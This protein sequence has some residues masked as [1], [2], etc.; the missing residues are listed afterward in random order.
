YRDY[1]GYDLNCSALSG[2]SIVLGSPEREP[3][4]IPFCQC[5]YQAAIHG[6][7]AAMA[8]LLARRSMRKGQHVDISTSEVMLYYARGMYLVTKEAGVGWKR[9]GTRQQVSIY[10]TGYFPCK[11]GHVCIASQSPRQWR[12][13]I[14][15]MGEPEWAKDPEMG[16]GMSLGI[17]NPDK[18][19]EVFK[20]WLM[21]RTRKQLLDMAMEHGLTMGL[22]NRIDEMVQDPHFKERGTWAEIDD[23]K[24][25]K[26]KLP[27]MSYLLS[28]TPWRITKPAPKLGEHNEEILTNKPKSRE[29]KQKKA[30]GNKKALKRPLEGYR[31]LDFGWNWAGPMTAQVLADMGAEVIKV[32]TSTKLDLMRY[33]PYLIHFFRQNNR[34]KLSVTVDIKQPGGVDLVKRLVKVSDIVLDNFSA[35]VMDRNGLGYSAL[36]EVKSDIICISM[37]MAGQ[38]GPLKD[39]KGFASIATGYAGLEGLVGYPEGKSTGMMSFGYG[40]T[41][42]AMQGVYSVLAALYH[43][44]QTGEGQFVDVSQI[45]A[46][47]ALMGEPILDYFL[48]GK[49]AEPRGNYHPEMAPYGIYPTKEED[50]WVS[51]AVWQE[52]EWEG[53]CRAVGQ[54]PWTKEERFRTREARLK[55]TESLNELVSEWT[56]KHTYYEA[57][58]ILQ[59]AGVAAVPVLGVD[60]GDSDPQLSE[61]DILQELKHPEHGPGVLYTTP[62]KLSETPGG[63]DRPTPRVGEHNDYIFKEILGMPEDEIK[64]LTEKNVIN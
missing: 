40:D 53:L 61:R 56:R 14:K 27:G 36:K 26:L 35:G 62:W 4:S 39:M 49:I 1:R 32:E 19:D 43:R 47:V 23:P 25:G 10:P 37:S 20:P 58:E 42:M 64:Q 12:K 9:R 22:V 11:D 63:I 44:E 15:L 5:E 50:R 24:L 29:A 38:F 54:P 60:D 59:K 51:I 34:S 6:A 48:N 33:L 3:L 31:V 57:A 41:N 46:V 21:E 8:A 2:V 18:G 16:D 7:A 13:F 52:E 30:S 28:E 45:E 17:Q 55:N